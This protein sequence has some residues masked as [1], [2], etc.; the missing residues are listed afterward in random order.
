M[1]RYDR[2]ADD[3]K[4][5]PGIMPVVGKTQA[6]AEDYHEELQQLVLPQDGGRRCRPLGGE[7]P[8]PCR[9]RAAQLA[10]F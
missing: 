9:R 7:V 1:A 3:L 5:L 6:E 4:I 10:D 2:P 8:R